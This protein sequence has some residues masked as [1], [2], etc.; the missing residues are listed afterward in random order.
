[1]KAEVNKLD[2]LKDTNVFILDVDGTLIDTVSFIESTYLLTLQT[3]KIRVTK[4]E[5]R[6]N[7]T[8]PAR[9]I[10]KILAPHI[11]G[12]LLHERLSSNQLSIL[13][14]V[15]AISGAV[16]T[17]KKFKERG[18]L[19]ATVTSRTK[20]TGIELLQHTQLN[21]LIDYKLFRDDITHAKPHPESLHMTLKYFGKMAQ[22]AVMIGDSI[23]DIEAG[24][25][26]G[27]KTVGVLTGFDKK[28]IKNA[29]P[30]LL[31]KDISYLS[32]YV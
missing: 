28:I 3:H 8:L 31:V 5:L 6:K 7:I 32:G 19:I 21:G 2:F 24:K 4:K 14:T 25:N 23:V 12:Q 18:G 22:N 17:L 27:V 1:M 9:D 20:D 26:A 16:E 15:S 29:H 30:D 13:H 10:F 11:D